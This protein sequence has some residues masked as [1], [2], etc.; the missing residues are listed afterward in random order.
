MSRSIVLVCVLVFV[1]NASTQKST[2][3]DELAQN[4]ITA[5]KYLWQL[6]YSTDRY[7]RLETLQHIYNTHEE[8][9]G[10]SFGELGLF[11]RLYV[12][13]LEQRLTRPHGS[14]QMVES[15]LEINATTLNVYRLLNHRFYSSIQQI[16]DDVLKSMHEMLATI[17]RAIDSKFWSWAIEVCG[18]R[19]HS[20][21]LIRSV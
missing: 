1:S 6:I 9:L 5:E 8:H 19:F 20:V 16:T 12:N 13:L 10:N 15:V 4:Y 3:V 17:G 18:A 14:L 2:N 7:N 21:P 11:E